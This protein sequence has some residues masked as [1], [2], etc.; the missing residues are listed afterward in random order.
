MFM[1]IYYNIN[2]SFIKL[3]KLIELND[4]LICELYY[5][6]LCLSSV[7]IINL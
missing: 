3:L 7:N 6:I 4:N 1:F 5:I 2:S